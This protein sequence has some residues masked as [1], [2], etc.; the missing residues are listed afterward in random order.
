VW[1]ALKL[2]RKKGCTQFDFVG[3]FDERIQNQFQSW[4][5]FTKF[6]K[7]FGGKEIYYPIK[8]R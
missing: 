1:E 3:V 4:K 5:G 2:S 8:Y 7:G 6:K